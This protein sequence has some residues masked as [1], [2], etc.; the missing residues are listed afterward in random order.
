MKYLAW[1]VALFAITVGLTGIVAPDRLLGLRSLVA[2]QGAL[3]V[4]GAIRMAFGVV[5]IMAAAGSRVPKTLRIVGAV[6]M[7]AGL[8]TPMFGIERTKVVMEWEV[9]QGPAFMRIVGVV[10]LALGGLLIFALIP[11]K[12]APA[13][14]QGSSQLPR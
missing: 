9:A 11:S 4:I 3:Y 12:G 10:V 8:S 7:L 2:T 13:R 1:I 6:M 14:D 5:L